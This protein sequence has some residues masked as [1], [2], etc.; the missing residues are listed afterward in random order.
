MN[1]IE[2]KPWW[3][4]KTIWGAI[5]VLLAMIADQAGIDIG[6]SEGA[7][8]LLWKGVEFAGAVLAVVGRVK[9]KHSIGK[10]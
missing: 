5:A 3:Q 6:G 1:E 2:P 8:D 10:K 9:A 7:S 4:S